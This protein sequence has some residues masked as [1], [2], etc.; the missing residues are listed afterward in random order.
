MRRV[1]FTTCLLFSSGCATTS[2]APPQVRMD[3]EIYANTQQT[4]FN[5][6]CTPN[7][8]N[9]NPR[10]KRNV[11][12]ALALIDNYLLTYRCQRDRA[13]EGRQ[14]FEVPAFLATAG[15]AAAAAFGAPAAVAIGTSAGSAVL[16]QG[17]SYYAPKDKAKVLSDGVRA[18]LCIHNEAVGIDGPTLEAISQVQRNS[19]PPKDPPGDEADTGGANLVGLMPSGDG[20]ASVSVTYDRQYFNMISTALLS[21]EQLVAER[22]SDSG[23]QFDLSGVLAEL[24]KLKQEAKDKEAAANPSGDAA[25]AA[26]PITGAPP[27]Q[28]APGAPVS[29][30]VA[31]AQSARLQ[32]FNLA[33]AAVTSI[34]DEQVGQTVIQL[35]TLKPKLDQCVVQAKV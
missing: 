27:P 13:A 1:L 31:I 6:T 35:K 23:R 16:G 34:G 5:A 21:V 22:L 14:F 29:S 32:K 10:I 12:G 3:R 4:F 28:T 17:K 26:D 19:G 11:E 33:K 18:M 30:L 25:E 20:G 7:H 9:T 15:G 8:A 2:F 24:D